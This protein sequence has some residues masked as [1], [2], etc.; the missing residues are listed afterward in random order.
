MSE[1]EAKT[2]FES[3]NPDGFAKDAQYQ[4]TIR[5]IIS[6]KVTGDVMDWGCGSRVFYDVGAAKSWTGIDIS[7]RMLSS[8]HFHNT[9]PDMKIVNDDILDLSFADESVD[10]IVACFILHHLALDGP[11][12][13]RERVQKAFD[14]AFRLLR[15]GGCFI[16]CENCRG[17]LEAPYHW[18]FPLAF[19]LARRL[20]NTDLPYFWTNHQYRRFGTNA[21]FETPVSF[22]NVPITDWIYNP[23][24]RFSVPPILSHDLIQ[25]MTVFE[26][27]KASIG[28]A[29]GSPHS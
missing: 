7:E 16:V 26:F 1:R 8:I 18:A 6:K 10:V 22:V 19:P 5:H 28:D 23:V 14:S 2:S 13:S 27:R 20:L 25:K 11:K 4:A 15:P 3:W 9:I 29:P 17:P 24:L 12:T 21:G